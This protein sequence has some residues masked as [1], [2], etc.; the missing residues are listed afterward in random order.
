MPPVVAGSPSGR[1]DRRFRLG[2]RQFLLFPIALAPLCC[3]LLRSD[4]IDDTFSEG[5]R[6]RD[7]TVTVRVLD[8]S[9]KRPLGTFEVVL[10]YGDRN[11]DP[12][13]NEVRS[14]GSA[15]SATFTI[16]YP[17]FR[18]RHSG[19]PDGFAFFDED[20]RYRLE[21]SADGYATASSPFPEYAVHR[22]E[23]PPPVL[24]PITVELKR[25][26]ATQGSEDLDLSGWDRY[27]RKYVEAFTDLRLSPEARHHAG[28]YLTR[29]PSP[30]PEEIIALVAG[31]L[32][33]KHPE[34]QLSAAWVLGEI[35]P[36]APAKFDIWWG[37]NRKV[38]W[39][40]YRT[41]VPRYQRWWSA[42]RN[43]KSS[44]KPD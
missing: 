38:F 42:R 39:E 20:M 21:V 8:A 3:C 4:L 30:H 35:A 11:S 24:P 23:F 2:V 27:R 36:D 37:G 41:N 14:T 13:Y 19:R 29:C 34:V 9:T 1:R 43:G 10:T 17:T 7:G 18:Y 32:D 28:F 40:K 26:A 31:E 33:S 6:Y 22:R 25:K 16:S 5:N 44:S 15:G 12:R